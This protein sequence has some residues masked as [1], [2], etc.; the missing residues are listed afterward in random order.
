MLTAVHVAVAAAA[1]AFVTVAGVAVY[2]MLKAA[3]LMSEASAAVAGLRERGD[4]LID[5]AN[6]AVD[7]ANAAVDQAGA[8]ADRAREQIASRQAVTASVEGVTAAMAGPGGHLTAMALH[9][10]AAEAARGPLTWAAA[11]AYGVRWALRIRRAAARD[12]ARQAGRAQR[13]PGPA[14]QPRRR[15]PRGGDAG[16]RALLTGRANGS[17]R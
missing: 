11:L 17:H 2:V 12:A 9:P 14:P 16:R 6:A 7:R 3:R 10:A 8:A 15:G 5:R 1:A 13:W 4:L